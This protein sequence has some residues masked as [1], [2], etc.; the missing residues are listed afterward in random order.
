[1]SGDHHIGKCTIELQIAS[2]QNAY[3]LQQKIS[4]MVWTILIPELSL[5][6][7][8]MVGKHEVI[9][10][11]KLEIEIGNI[12]DSNFNLGETTAEIVLQL[13]KKLQNLKH[14]LAAGN[15]Q[16]N[17]S[18]SK[19]E[20]ISKA[21]YQYNNWLYWLEWGV[22]PSNAIRTE[23]RWMELVLEQ[24]A[25]DHDAT[26][27]LASLLKNNYYAFKRLILQHDRADLIS[28]TELYTG[29]SQKELMKGID[30][31]SQVFRQCKQQN[32]KPTF[33]DIEI[34]VWEYIFEKSILKRQKIK[35]ITFLSNILYRLKQSEYEQ[36]I[37]GEVKK[38]LIK[39][40][41]LHKAIKILD[42]PNAIHEYAKD[43][44]NS[45]VTEVEKSEV[46][47]PATDDISNTENPQFFNNAGM[48]ILH[49][50]LYN[51]FNRLD[52]IKEKKFKD[53]VSRSKA[54]LLL[55][56]LAEGK[57]EVADFDLALPK[58][59]C[60]MPLNV[61]IDRQL[62]ISK[63]EKQEAK[64]LLKVVIQHWDA[65]GATSPLG[66]Q[67]GFLQRQGKLINDGQGWK[68]SVEHKTIDILLDRLPWNLSMIKLPWM[69]ELLHVEWR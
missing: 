50:F 48:V 38:D 63:I 33:R 68:L 43:A 22:L 45:F 58:F 39:Y 29:F 34:N 2:S 11:D 26:I 12:Q 56:F 18:G 41:I 1:M 54:V 62:S 16:K 6:F 57:E 32:A 27:L 52:L 31:I 53:N 21:Q 3:V 9:R 47:Q 61:P 66:L 30:E 14:E 23:H 49:P 51:F 15:G 60:Q 42:T 13:E 19:D 28:I 59:L 64:K 46:P 36:M 7:D 44:K 55:N 20:N 24:L 5:L 10:L 37:F 69:K 35:G 17:A 67:Q 8:D 4:E 40:S 25:L 65:L